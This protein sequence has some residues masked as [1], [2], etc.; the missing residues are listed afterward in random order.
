MRLGPDDTFWVVTDA[1]PESEMADVCFRG[2]LR[3][4]ERQFKGGLTMANNPTL[5]TDEA[6]AR[7]EADGRL[8]A[9]RVA[10]A[11][12]RRAAEGMDL[13]GTCSV[14]VLD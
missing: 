11:I 7:R 13:A 12:A 1:S 10:K 14:S 4:I 2:S 3:G 9:A 8:L 5:F 6:E